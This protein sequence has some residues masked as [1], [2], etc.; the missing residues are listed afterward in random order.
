MIIPIVTYEQLVIMSLRLIET[1]V[2][3]A[4]LGSFSAAGKALNLSPGS[5]SQNIKNLEDHLGVRLFQRTTRQIKLTPEGERY[6]SRV[7]PAFEALSEAAELARADRDDLTGTIK[8]TSTTAFGRDE[9]MPVIAA[10]QNK[11]PALTIELRLSD[12]FAD[13]VAE[14]FDVAIRGGILPDSEYIARLLVPV[15]PMLCASPSYLERYGLPATIE[16][17]SGHR[18][19]GMRSNPSSRVFAWEFAEPKG[20]TKRQEFA[21]SFIVNDPAGLLRAATMGMGIAQIGSN[22]AR[23]AIDDGVLIHL[24]PDTIV[25]SRGLYAV[26]PSRR[27]L[28]RKVSL[29][30]AALIEAFGH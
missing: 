27:F 19:I 18:L 24:L 4:R 29:F 8:I 28:P 9:I 11:H 2:E 20:G 25:Q 6:R 5:V 30:V 12:E 22:L 17:L 10:F 16:A 1:F 23:E 14:G 26:Y 3:A 7:A 21:P 13:L 15:T